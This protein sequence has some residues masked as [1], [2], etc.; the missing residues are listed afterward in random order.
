MKVV[1]FTLFGLVQGVNVGM[2][3]INWNNLPVL[4][5]FTDTDLPV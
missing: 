1:I 4:T 3:V 2:S 5:V